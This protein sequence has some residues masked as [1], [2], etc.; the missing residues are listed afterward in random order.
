MSLL[1]STLAWAMDYQERTK[2][3]PPQ[4][5]YASRTHAQLKQ[6][7]GE[8]NKLCYQ[9][10]LAILSSRDQSCANEDLKLLRGQDK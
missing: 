3:P 9:V 6:V 10:K 2:E 1:C 7:V 8:L 5:I 4:I